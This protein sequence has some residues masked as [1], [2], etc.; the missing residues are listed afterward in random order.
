[1]RCPA[2]L[3]LHSTRDR[4]TGWRG[5]S[6]AFINIP[7]MK[8][9]TNYAILFQLLRDATSKKEFA[10]IQCIWLKLT[11]S[12]NSKQIALAIGSTPVSVRRIQARF[13]NEG[14]KCFVSKPTG[15]RKRENISVEREKK[16]LE[17]FMRQAKRGVPLNV[18]QVK[19]AYELSAG[20]RV[21][22]STIYRLINR[23]GLRR[24]LPRAKQKPTVP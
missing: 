2:F 14:L 17:K 1:M 24:F 3:V 4:Q 9:E 15:G 22:P 8:P 5:G 21:P 13:A 7:T 16:I 12:L 18:Q 19:R 10:R 6:R 20:K 23:Y 11:L